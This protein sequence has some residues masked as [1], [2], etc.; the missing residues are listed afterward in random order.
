M[1][2]LKRIARRAMLERGLQPEFSPEA[3]ARTRSITEPAG[4]S[5]RRR[6]CWGPASVSSSTR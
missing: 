1:D 3:V 4:A 2:D 5:P 6:R